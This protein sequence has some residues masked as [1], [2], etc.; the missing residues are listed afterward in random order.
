MRDLPPLTWAEVRCALITQSRSETGCRTAAP[1]GV[2][3]GGGA[4][5][6]YPTG[7]AEREKPRQRKSLPGLNLESAHSRTRTW[8]PLINSQML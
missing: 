8:D 3:T 5:A 6:T 7:G 4:W 2:R 1:E